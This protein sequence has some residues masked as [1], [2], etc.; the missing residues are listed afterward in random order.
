MSTQR[1]LAR[2]NRA[3]GNRIF[4]VVL[5]RLPGF[6]AVLHRGRRSGKVYRTPV[7]VFR[8]DGRY[9]IALAYGPDSDWVRNVVAAGGCDLVVVGRRVR[10]VEPSLFVDHTQSVI[11]AVARP[12]FRRFK[13]FDF[14]E[15]RP[16]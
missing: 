11:P 15:L 13:T 3:V 6:G 9:V 1:T 8:R 10:L 7:K 2:F 14:M 12:L 5:S 4:G 16:A